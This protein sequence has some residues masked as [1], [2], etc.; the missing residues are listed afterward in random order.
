MVKKE[1]ALKSRIAEFCRQKE[2]F[3]QGD[4]VVVG[5][6]GGADSVCL[7]LVLCDLAKE[8]ELTLVPV[9]V[10]H[11][12]RGAEADADQRFCEE[13]CC[14]H[15]LLLRVVS[16]EVE[17]LA[18]EYGWTLE[19]A[20]RN[21]R[22]R[23]FAETA[24]QCCCQKI[25]VA[26]HKNDQ[27][28]TVLFQLFR[29]SRLKGLSGMEAKN[30]KLVRP[31]LAVERKEIEGFLEEK[32]QKFCID[33]TN[34]CEDYTRNL[35]RHRMLPVAQSI[36]PKAVEHVA[37]TAEYLGRVE[38]LLARQ[39][40]AIYQ[41]AVQQRE[42]IVEIS[43]PV[44]SNAEP[45]LAE[46][47]IYRALCAA[48]GRKKDISAKFVA[49]CMALC[50]KQTGRKISLPDGMTVIKKYDMLQISREPSGDKKAEE[51]V[52]VK[53]TEFPYEAFLPEIGK[54]MVLDLWETAENGEISEEKL[55]F[56]PKS[57][58]TKSF[59]YD[60]IEEVVSLGYPETET[61]IALYA[62]GRGKRVLDVLKEAKVP[63]EKRKHYPVLAAGTQVLWIP[64]IRGSEA[65][66][67]T[68]ETKRILTATIDGGDEDGG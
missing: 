67:V 53:I 55:R 33:R 62:D 52:P 26:H 13:L 43:I 51:F 58:Y 12:L 63:A 4:R 3:Q 20:G 37:E 28:E 61:R 17:A 44:L 18:K 14:Q 23:A 36:Q 30:G 49:D 60:K 24:E 32:K 45:L 9:H 27:A 34:S 42:A 56:I 16:V 48:A 25:A 57:T 8:W 50:S 39:T 64:G 22:Y 11:N 2:L 1:F 54:K 10:N 5:L 38:E 68:K 29:G 19:E 40:G 6:S 35:I 7:F 41:Q 47:V 66:Y 46:R 21:A 65:Y 31:L 59:D 15:N